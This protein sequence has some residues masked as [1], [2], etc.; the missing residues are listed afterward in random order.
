MNK[1][2]ACNPKAEAGALEWRQALLEPGQTMLDFGE[3]PPKVGIESSVR[4]E[5]QGCLKTGGSAQVPVRA[6][7]HT[8]KCRCPT[9]AVPTKQ[10]GQRTNVLPSH[11]FPD[12]NFKN[13]VE[14]EVRLAAVFPP[15]SCLCPLPFLADQ[16]AQPTLLTGWN[17]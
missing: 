3:T 2:Q 9:F 10:Q 1:I 11:P 17:Q 13:P 4:R 5:Y 7:T 16:T 8:R 12:Q 15:G 6:L 14:S